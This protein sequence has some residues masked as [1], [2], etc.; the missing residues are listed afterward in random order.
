MTF[1]KLDNVNCVY[2]R[3]YNS[4]RRDGSNNDYKYLGDFNSYE[5]CVKVITYHNNNIGGWARQCFSINDNNT[6]VANQNYVV[7]GIR[8]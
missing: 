4:Y 2:G 3:L 5:D 6:N 1:E 8:Q 7:C